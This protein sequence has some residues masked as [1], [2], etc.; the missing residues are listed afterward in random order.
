MHELGNL[1]L[2][3]PCVKKHR[4]RAV[5]RADLHCLIIGTIHFW[6]CDGIRTPIPRSSFDS[7]IN[8]IIEL[9]HL[10]IHSELDLDFY[11]NVFPSNM[12]Q[13][14]EQ[15]YSLFQAGNREKRSFERLRHEYVFRLVVEMTARK[16]EEVLLEGNYLDSIHQHHWEKCQHL[17]LSSDGRGNDAVELYVRSLRRRSRR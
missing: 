11:Q 17:A 4:E 10:W 14:I 12:N 16:N 8:D 6:L 9:V 7:E 3:L 15:C 1:V 2:E 13:A 5:N